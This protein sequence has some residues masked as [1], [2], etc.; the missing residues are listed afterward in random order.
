VV[1]ERAVVE[2][3][4]NIGRLL[5]D[6]NEDVAGLVVE[7]LGGVIVADLLDGVTNDLLKVDLCFRGDLPEN[8]DHASLGGRLA[9][10]FGRRV[11]RQARVKL[12]TNRR[13]FS[14]LPIKAI[15]EVFL[16][17]MASETWSQILSAS[18]RAKSI[19]E[20]GASSM[21]D[22]TTYRDG[23]HQRSRS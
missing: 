20:D 4:S 15:S 13:F 3:L 2:T 5:F 12:V 18:H 17:T 21:R 11:L 22:K 23:L 14:I 1:F 8:H 10:D 16:L 7:A 6:G 9:S 19:I